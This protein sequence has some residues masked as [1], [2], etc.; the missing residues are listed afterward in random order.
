MTPA[1]VVTVPVLDQPRLLFPRSLHNLPRFGSTN[2]ENE[3]PLAFSILV[4]IRISPQP[5]I[6]HRLRGV[7]IASGTV[8][9]CLQPRSE[10]LRLGL[11]CGV[12]T[13]A[14]DTSSVV[15][16]AQ[17]EV[18]RSAILHERSYLFLLSSICIICLLLSPSPSES[19]F[20]PFIFDLSPSCLGTRSSSNILRTTI[21]SMLPLFSSTVLLLGGLVAAAPYADTEEKCHPRTICVDALSPCGVKYGG[22]AITLTL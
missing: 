16:Y 3:R 20:S 21:N 1:N 18:S 11:R 5:S 13:D 22:Y 2:P 17:V 4:S 7:L 10:A 15:V 14:L 12:V 19:T 6:H 9:L 8:F